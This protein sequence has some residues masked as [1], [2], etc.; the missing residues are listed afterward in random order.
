MYMLFNEYLFYECVNFFGLLHCML[1]NLILLQNGTISHQ[2]FMNSLREWRLA[3]LVLKEDEFEVP[4]PA[5][6]NNPHA[7]HVDGNRKLYRFNKTKY[8]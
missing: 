3:Q 5:C 7:V 2:I 8:V 1:L 6:D 4:C